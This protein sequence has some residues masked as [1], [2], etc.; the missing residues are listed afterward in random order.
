MNCIRMLALS[1][2]NTG[3]NLA[4]I[5]LLIFCMHHVYIDDFVVLYLFVQ[6]NENANCKCLNK[7]NLITKRV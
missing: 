2:F 6:M 1:S 3:T 5:I 4:K 7:L